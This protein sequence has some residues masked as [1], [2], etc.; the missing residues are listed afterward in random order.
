MKKVKS[1]TYIKQYK[2]YFYTVKRLHNTKYGNPN[3]EIIIFQNVNKHFEILGETFH[4]STYNN[5]IAE[6]ENHINKKG[7]KENEV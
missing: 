2:K 6:V 4:V 7:V 3:Y 1:N 5:I